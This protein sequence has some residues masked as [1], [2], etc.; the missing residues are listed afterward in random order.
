[1]RKPTR[2]CGRKGDSVKSKARGHDIEWINDHWIYADTGKPTVENQRD[3]C[4]YCGLTDTPEGHDACLGTLIGTMNACCGHGQTNEAYI[5]FWDSR[6]VRGQDAIE[7][8]KII[9][10]W[11]D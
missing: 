8:M 1:M 2:L 10:K 11:S 4:G 6:C 7:V 5:Q 9:Q 3:Y